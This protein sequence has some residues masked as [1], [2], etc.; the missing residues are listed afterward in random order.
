MNVEEA[1]DCRRAVEELREL[2][3]LTGGPEGARRVCWTEEWARAREW[4]RGLLDEIECEVEV[5][6]AGNLWATAPG[7]SERAVILGGHL[8]SVPNGGWLDGCLNIIAAL[9][10]FRVLAPRRRPVTLRLVDWADE[11]GARFGRSLL[12]SSACA[13]T[14]NP[15]E[16]RG[17]RD[18][19][20]V[21]LPD[22]LREHG[23]ELDRMNESHRQLENAAAYLELHIEQGPV[24]DRLGLPLGVVLGTFGV[25][26]H[27]VRFTGRHAHSGAT[28]M[29]A[30]RDAFIAAARSAVAFRD[31][32]AR[33]DDVRA[34]TGFVNVRPGI[35][36]AFN[37]WCEMS[38][39]QRALRADVLADMLEVAKEN[40]GRIAEEEGCEVEWERLWRIEPVPFDGGLIELA[41]EAVREVAGTSHRLPSGPLH[42]AAEMARLMPAVMLFVRSLRG[43]SHTKE[44]DTPVED[45][46]MSVR[47][48]HRLAIK[49][50]DWVAGRTS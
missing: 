13:G 40:S 2:D 24:L 23:V 18:R 44:E 8:D 34:T 38:L 4:L 25:E 46:E 30:R 37:G 12:G 9:E 21:A 15:D 39:D 47:A 10:S 36:T 27:A 33:R 11:E 20:G 7:D 3:R 26:R 16:V 29:D 14:L 41:E 42:D 45:V 35:V 22:A 6:E 19:D 28:P 43:L 31:D 17:L 1:V 50:M 48:L 5:D 32:A 49:T